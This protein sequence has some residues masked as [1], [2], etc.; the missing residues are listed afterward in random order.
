MN[1]FTKDDLELILGHPHIGGSTFVLG[2]L[3]N[4]TPNI[5]CYWRNNEISERG[6]AKINKCDE[7]TGLDL[8][9]K[10]DGLSKKDMAVISKQFV[11][12]LSDTEM[13][14]TIRSASRATWKARGKISIGGAILLNQAFGVSFADMRPDKPKLYWPPKIKAYKR[15]L[16]AKAEALPCS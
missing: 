3:I 8:K 6:L 16:A 7:L 4:E 10:P 14:K 9:L 11:D 12:G 5:I 13:G 1:T 15:K 2:A